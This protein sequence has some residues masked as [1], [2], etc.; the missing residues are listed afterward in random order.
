[1]RRALAGFAD[2]SARPSLRCFGLAGA[3]EPAA[4]TPHQEW[5]LRVSVFRPAEF[6]QGIAEARE[7]E[8]H[9]IEVA[10]FDAGD[11]AA[12]AALDG[13]GAGFVGGFLGW[14]VARELFVG[15]RGEM[16]VAGF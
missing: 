2:R 7:R 3:S 11:V 12:R 14:E 8:T 6:G 15:K 5:L 9:D 10:T 1:M 4:G 13:G 16:D